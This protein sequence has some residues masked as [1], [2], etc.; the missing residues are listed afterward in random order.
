MGVG[1]GVPL[2]SWRDEPQ[3][4]PPSAST[5]AAMPITSREQFI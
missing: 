5:I 2:A 4:A 3:P 1:A